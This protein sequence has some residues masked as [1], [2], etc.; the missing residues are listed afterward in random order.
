MAK[1]NAVGSF[2]WIGALS[3]S[4]IVLVGSAAAQVTSRL[5]LSSG[6]VQGN[7]QSDSCALSADGRFAAFRGDSVNFVVGDSNALGDI[8][9]R[10][11]LLGT[12][13]RVSVDSA[14]IQSD[15]ESRRPSISSGGRYVAFE[16]D[17]T[18]LVSGDTNGREDVFVHDRQTAT[19]ERVSV[20][21]SGAQGN[22]HSVRPSISGDG[23]YVAF[24]SDSTN[25]VAGDTNG[26]YDIFVHDRQTG[27][28]ERVSVDSS[29]VEAN[30]SS[31][32][33]DVSSDG[34]YVAFWG[35]ATNL[36][37]GDSNAQPDVFI[38]DRQTS[39][40][41]R[42][43]LDSS[44]TEANGRSE[45]CA[46]SDD[47]RYVVFKSEA[48]NLVVGDTNARIDIFARDR[49]TGVTER[50]SV[51][52]NGTESNHTNADAAIS[53]DGRCVS[54]TSFASNLVTGDANGTWDIF[55]HDRQTGITERTSVDSNGLEGNDTSNTSSI[56]GDGRH[57]AFESSSSN[58]V[59]GDTNNRQDVFVRD[60][61]GVNGTKYCVSNPNSTGFP[62]SISVAGSASASVGDMTLTAE[63]VPNQFGVFFH[64]VNQA[65]V[66]FGNGFLC[67][68][69]GLTR[70]AVI[71]AS[72]NV[73]NYVYDNSDAKHSFSAFAN[74]TRNFQYWF[75][76]P[77]GGGAAF[78]TSNAVSVPLLP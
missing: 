42:V 31:L 78:N 59:T 41:E 43:S 57:V 27:S 68:T 66:S 52:S 53:G 36:V 74:S 50:I 37:M 11:Y 69:G 5:S 12:T 6:E 7:D 33:P 25:L 72:A 28:T 20:H 70:G 9:V 51:D 49:Q 10:D 54:F 18:N 34:R 47:G 48:T 38:H 8:F 63:P 21:S 58:L 61:T 55:I 26:A 16:S 77:M 32:D 15:G 19:T 2:G 30:S 60:R 65:Q 62:A 76:D 56:S 44:A 14:G 4:A 35:S 46:L 64:G 45:D 3:C 39:M 22:G 73:A 24:A 67:T 1:C 75:R 23:R 40:T 13:E 71:L 29:G 17:A